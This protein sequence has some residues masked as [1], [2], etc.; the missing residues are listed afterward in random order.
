MEAIIDPS[1]LTEEQR[2]VIRNIINMVKDDLECHE[3]IC[4]SVTTSDLA[5]EQRVLL[6]ELFGE[7]FFKEG[8]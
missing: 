6:V 4:E 8:E 7:N 3:T 1:T 5:E 2:K